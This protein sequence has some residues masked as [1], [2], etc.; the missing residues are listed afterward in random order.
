M[1]A[2]LQPLVP[3][4]TTTLWQ[5]QLERRPHSSDSSCSSSCSGFGSS[6]TAAKSSIVCPGLGAQTQQRW[7]CWRRQQSSLPR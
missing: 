2:R 5:L 3:G 6:S 1:Q 7:W 4:L